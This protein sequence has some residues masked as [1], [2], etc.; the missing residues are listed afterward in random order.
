MKNYLL[1]LAFVAGSFSLLPTSRAFG[2]EIIRIQVGKDYDGYSNEEMRRRLWQ[3]ER[4]VQQLQSRVFQLEMQGERPVP[5]VLSQNWTCILQSF[6]TTHT[7]SSS[8]RTAALAM[9]LKKCSDAT[10]AIHCR[11]S[12]VKCS[13]E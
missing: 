1:A 7:A 4:A 9:V 11:E 13:N 6:G 12:E 3:L 8:T 10:N 5:I 2:E